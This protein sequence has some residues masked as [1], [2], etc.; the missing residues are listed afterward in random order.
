MREKY[1]P[2]TMEFRSQDLE[3]ESLHTTVDGLLMQGELTSRCHH[4]CFFAFFLFNFIG[5]NNK[6]KTCIISS[7]QVHVKTAYSVLENI[8]TTKAVMIPV[9]VM[10]V[11][12]RVH[13][14]ASNVNKQSSSLR[15]IGCTDQNRGR[16]GF[17]EHG[18][19]NYPVLLNWYLQRCTKH[20]PWILLQLTE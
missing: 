19:Y 12:A 20:V 8:A 2:N 11:C 3:N 14:C 4:Q 6:S 13:S 10:C 1:P 7:I 5:L 9:Q 16:K 17:W 15:K 18:G